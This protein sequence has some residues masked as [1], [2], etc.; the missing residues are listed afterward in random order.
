MRNKFKSAINS[1]LN[2]LGV[3]LVSRDWGP[4]GYLVSLLAARKAGIVP[5]I[6]FDIGAARREW[7]KET[8]SIF[9]VSRFVLVDQLPENRDA[10]DLVAERIGNAVVHTAALGSKSGTLAIRVH[11]DQSSF[12]KSND[13]SGEC[14][15]V[16]VRT[17]DDILAREIEIGTADHL[18]LKLDVQGF[19]IEVLKGATLALDSTDILLV[20]VSFQR[21]YEGNPLAHGVITIPRLSRIC[22]L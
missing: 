19:E 11:G 4:R 17:C 13:F 20:E 2:G 10:L 18:F 6:V 3:G 8:V 21:I 7:S 12:L 22:C 15:K 14:V 1:A 16:D 5:D 9:P